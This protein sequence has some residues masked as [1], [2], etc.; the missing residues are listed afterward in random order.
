M[1][2]GQL[3]R[4]SLL[5]QP[6]SVQSSKRLNVFMVTG[7]MATE[8]EQGRQ[9][10][11]TVAWFLENQYDVELN[12]GGVRGISILFIDWLFTPLMKRFPAEKLKESVEVTGLGKKNRD[13]FAEVVQLRAKELN[14]VH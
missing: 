8:R 3:V 1:T 14:Y 9:L 12:F 13:R 2:I 5:A 4:E 11:K 6:D 7:N 10:A